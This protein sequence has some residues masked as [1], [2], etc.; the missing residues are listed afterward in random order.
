[1]KYVKQ[2]KSWRMSCDVG[3]AME[4]LENELAHWIDLEERNK[5][6][7]YVRVVMN[8]WVP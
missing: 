3:E 6:R 5:W 4:R 8:F 7:A 2:S 1:M